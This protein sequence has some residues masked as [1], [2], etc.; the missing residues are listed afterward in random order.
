MNNY[1]Y[2]LE[3]LMEVFY[4]IGGVAAEND[5]HHQPRRDA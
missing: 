5:Q 4:F 1:Q 3:E 2:F